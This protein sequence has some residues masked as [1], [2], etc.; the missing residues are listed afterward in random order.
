MLAEFPVAI[1]LLLVFLTI[2]MIDL[3]TIALRSTFMINAVHEAAHHAARAKSFQTPVD[4]SEQSAQQ[5]AQ[6][7]IS[8]YFQD[9][10]GIAV[11]SVTLNIVTVSIS[12]GTITRQNSPLAQQPDTNSNT[13]S[14]EVAV[15]ATV[16]PLL[17]CPWMPAVP[18]L[19]SPIPVT[20]ATQEFSEFPQGLTQ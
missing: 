2:P 9:F 4:Q 12:N 3:A 16:D 7:V 19:A 8:Q 10:T 11:Q 5:S 15:S 14:L 1:W 20:Y 13:Y 6:N 17:T 18:G